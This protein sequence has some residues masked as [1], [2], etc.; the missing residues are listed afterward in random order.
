MEYASYRRT[1]KANKTVEPTVNLPRFNG[2]LN[3]TKDEVSDGEVQQAKEDLAI[4]K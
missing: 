4:H 2:H 3:Q 1:D